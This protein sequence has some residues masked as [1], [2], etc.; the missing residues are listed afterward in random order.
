MTSLN[1]KCYIG[2]GDENKTSCKGVIQK[3][4]LLDVACFNSVLDT[5]ETH[6]VIN[7]GFKVL[8]KHIVTYITFRSMNTLNILP[9][10]KYSFSPE[11]IMSRKY[12]LYIGNKNK[13][14]IKR[15]KQLYKRKSYEI[16]TV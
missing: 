8:D 11:E 14:Y 10:C 15:T 6:H 2:C 5:K 13:K 9:R 3:Q 12:L 1:S 4:N 16:P 7:T